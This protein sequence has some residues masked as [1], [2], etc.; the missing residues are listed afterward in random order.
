MGFKEGRI[1]F[2][3]TD[4]KNIRSLNKKYFGR[5]HPTDVIAFS[6]DDACDPLNTLGEIVISTEQA[7]EN[8]GKFRTSIE[9][10]LL[11]YVLHGLLH[12]LGFEDKTKSGKN[13][14]K[15]IQKHLFNFLNLKEEV[16]S[17]SFIAGSS[18]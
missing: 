8:S 16:I 13:K 11:L 15:R 4:N 17:D 7:R 18:L 1:S 2:V 3:F 10:E 6:L 9:E 12:I 5:D 14:M